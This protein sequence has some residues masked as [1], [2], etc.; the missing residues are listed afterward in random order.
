MIPMLYKY[1]CIIKKKL[2]R[3]NIIMSILKSILTNIKFTTNSTAQGDSKCNP[4]YN[5]K[6][7][8]YLVTNYLYSHHLL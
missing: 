2:I 8:L 7:Q 3:L 4:I 5:F 1:L 6:N